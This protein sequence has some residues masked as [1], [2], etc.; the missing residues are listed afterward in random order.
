MNYIPPDIIWPEFRECSMLFD[1]AHF[2]LKDI[3]MAK[4]VA[5]RANVEP[6]DLRFAFHQRVE[7]SGNPWELYC[8][9]AVIHYPMG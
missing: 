9:G 4:T 8:R 3:E 5:R 1:R 6:V 2:T 7:L